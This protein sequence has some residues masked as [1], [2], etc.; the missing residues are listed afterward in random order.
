[1][2]GTEWSQVCGHEGCAS[3]VPCPGAGTGGCRRRW[4]VLA[5]GNEL[6]C[7]LIAHTLCCR[8]SWGAR[9]HFA[10]TRSG[11]WLELVQDS[12]ASCSGVAGSFCA[13]PVLSLAA[14]RGWDGA[15]GLHCTG[16]SRVWWC[17]LEGRAEQGV[18]DGFEY[19]LRGCRPDK[20][21]CG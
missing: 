15:G 4:L 18:P 20:S 21:S 8:V 6:G 14:S 9:T 11:N 2:K 13:A 1:M 3:A 19:L 5:A 16:V 12:S 10:V 17:Q 7:G